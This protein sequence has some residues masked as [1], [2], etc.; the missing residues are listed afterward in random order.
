[1]EWFER[2]IVLTAQVLVLAES[3]QQRSLGESRSSRILSQ[4]LQVRITPGTRSNFHKDL[5]L[6]LNL[7]LLTVSTC[8][9]P[10]CLL[11]QRGQGVARVQ[12]FL[13]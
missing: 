3:F 9:H 5:A 7:P 1:M 13:R 6:A 2:N 12:I 10:L 4:R 11:I 8:K